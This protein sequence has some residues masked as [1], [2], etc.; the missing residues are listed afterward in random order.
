VTLLSFAEVYMERSATR[1]IAASLREAAAALLSGSYSDLRVATKQHPPSMIDM[2]VFDAGRPNY[3]TLNRNAKGPKVIN[4]YITV[5]RA[6]DLPVEDGNESWIGKTGPLEIRVLHAQS[7]K[8]PKCEDDA[9]ALSAIV[10][11]DPSN[12]MVVA[13]AFLP[14]N[15]QGQGL[16]LKIYEAALKEAAKHGF[17]LAPD[18]CSRHGNTSTAAKRAWKSLARRFAHI[19]DVF[20]Y[21]PASKTSRRQPA[22]LEAREA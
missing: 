6:E 7:A 22:S 9:E 3:F 17:M 21:A 16:G 1:R 4:I 15:L 13:Q 20:F 2:M 12:V 5:P 19:G 11:V 14:K 10:G 8:I 18:F